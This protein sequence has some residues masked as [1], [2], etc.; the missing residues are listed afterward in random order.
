MHDKELPSLPL[1]ISSHQQE[2]YQGAQRANE[3]AEVIRSLQQE[4]EILRRE[5]AYSQES[6]GKEKDRIISAL[7]EQNLEAQRRIDQ[8]NYHIAKIANTIR[9]V[10]ASCSDGIR[11]EHKRQEILDA[12]EEIHVYSS[13]ESDHES[14]I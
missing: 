8:R 4:N 1:L 2:T 7:R 13:F 10:F 6:V 11:H 5:L 9:E 12:K 3:L 14:W